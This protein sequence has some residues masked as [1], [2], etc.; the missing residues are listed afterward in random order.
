MVAPNSA[1]VFEVREDDPGLVDIRDSNVAAKA[2]AE[3]VQRKHATGAGLIIVNN[4]VVRE[5]ATFS[6]AE[7]AQRPCRLQAA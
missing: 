4:L 2:V 7:D 3:S 5:I 1:T 6:T